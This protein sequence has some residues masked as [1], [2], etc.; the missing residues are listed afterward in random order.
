MSR[1]ESKGNKMSQHEPKPRPRSLL[2]P[3]ELNKI[4]VNRLRRDL[5]RLYRRVQSGEIPSP[6]RAKTL[7]EEIIR[8][9]LEA[10]IAR[11]NNFLVRRGLKPVTGE[12]AGIETLFMEARASW[13]RIVDDMF[14]A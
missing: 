11:I 13:N 1:T 10:H 12:E 7:G 9:E 14:R 4:T 3:P 2:Y 8:R 6:G 5:R